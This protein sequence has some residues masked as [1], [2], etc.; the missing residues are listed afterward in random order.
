MYGYIYITTNKIT[1]KQYIGKHRATTF[2]SKYKGSGKYLLRAFNKYGKEN[3]ECSILCECES[4]EELNSCEIEYI[5]KFDA[6]NSDNFYNLASGGEGHTAKFSAESK[7]KSSISH[8]GYVPTDIARQ[9]MKEA[10]LKRAKR[11]PFKH[12]CPMTEEHKRK[13]VESRRRN[14]TYSISEEVRQRMSLAHKEQIPWNKGLTGL[15]YN[16]A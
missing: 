10:A 2:N 16:K 3:F 5:K 4:L 11:K 8:L 13:I 14:N 6:V 7:L 15:V 9:H 1:G 12:K